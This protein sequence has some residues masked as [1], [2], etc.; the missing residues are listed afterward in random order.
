MLGKGGKDATFADLA[1]LAAE[2]YP[3]L[4]KATTKPGSG[5]QP[6][7]SGAGSTTKAGKAVSAADLEKMTPQ[8][9]YD[10]FKANPHTTVTP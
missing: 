7:A 2:K 4:F 8:Q 3:S 6:G 10:F 1:A 5:T 9:K